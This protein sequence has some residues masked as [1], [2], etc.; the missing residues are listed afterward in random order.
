[1][2]GVWRCLG[3]TGKIRFARATHGDVQRGE[4]PL[5]G[6]WGCPRF[7][8]FFPQEESFPGGPGHFLARVWGCA[9]ITRI[10]LF[11]PM[12]GGQ[13]VETDYLDDGGSR[14]SLCALRFYG[15][16]ETGACPYKM[17]GEACCR[18][19]QGACHAPLQDVS[20][21]VRTARLAREV[22]Q[23]AA[24]GWGV[25]NSLHLLPRVGARGLKGG[26]DR[27]VGFA[28]ALPTLH[29]DSRLCG[30]DRSGAGCFLPRVWGCPPNS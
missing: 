23:G 26:S 2:P 3:I 29:V 16:S 24:G 18:G 22:Q 8:Q 12:I 20:L 4:A 7:P 1:V 10:F 28:F 21:L 15:S 9:P 13:G 30:N 27:V 11:S 17:A 14:F 6:V 5:L 25:P 19:V